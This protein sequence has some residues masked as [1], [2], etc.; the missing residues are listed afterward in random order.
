MQALGRLVIDADLLEADPARQALEEA[1]AL[2]HLA[3][4]L[5]GARREQAEIAGIFGDL[6]ARA[7]VEQRVER[8]AGEPAQRG[9]VLAVGLRGVDDVVA[10]I[11]PVADQ[12]FDQR[13]RML[14]VAVHEQ[15]RAEAR[16]IEAG[17]ERCL[18]AEIARQRDHLHVERARGQLA[19]DSKR[20]VAAA[21]IDVDDF[22]RELARFPQIARDVGQ[23]LVQ[24][25]EAVRLVEHG[26]DDREPGF[27]DRCY[28]YSIGELELVACG[29]GA[30]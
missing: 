28:T 19:R 21:V 12:R 24:P 27:H 10:A 13:R 8:L 25:R 2:R 16:M 22:D 1:V 3:Q 7:P 11:E 14:P 26:N 9:L 23:P 5:R 18:L 6:V 15:H 29:Q 4:R 20:V 30:C 17:G